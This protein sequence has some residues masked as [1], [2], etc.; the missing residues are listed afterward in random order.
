[1]NLDEKIKAG[2]QEYLQLP[3]AGEGENRYAEIYARNWCQHTGVAKVHPNPHRHYTLLEFA[4]WVG[5]NPSLYRRF[6]LPLEN[7]E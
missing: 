3:L 7:H 5:H 2:Y 6:I 4:Y 1:M